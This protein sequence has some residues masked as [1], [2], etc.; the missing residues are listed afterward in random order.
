M[1]AQLA[2]LIH[3]EHD[4]VQAWRLSGGLASELERQGKRTLTFPSAAIVDH[5][6]ASSVANRSEACLRGITSRLCT[7]EYLFSGVRW[8]E[9]PRA[10]SSHGAPRRIGILTLS[11]RVVHAALKQVLEPMVDHRFV[12]D[13]FGFRAARSVTGALDRALHLLNAR[14]RTTA[15]FRYLARLDVADCFETLQHQ[16]LLQEV[17]GATADAA[18]LQILGNAL[19]ATGMV[20]GRWWWRR[21]AGVVQGS[22]LSPLLCNLYLHGVD[23]ELARASHDGARWRLLRYADDMLLLADS[24]RSC[25][26]GV[27]RIA[28]ALRA[29]GQSLR[30]SKTQVTT[31]R[32]GASWLGVDIRLGAADQRYH[33]LI[34]TSR[35][36]AMRERI[37]EMTV[38]PSERIDPAAFDMGRWLGS[39]NE[40]MMDWWHAYRYA[41]NG[42]FVFKQIDEF[43][44]ERVGELLPS[45]M[46]RTWRQVKDEHQVRLPRGF[47]SW[48]IQ[49]VTLTLLSSLPPHS[50][51]FLSR[52]PLWQMRPKA[53]APSA[54][55]SAR[56]SGNG[57]AW[58]E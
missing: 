54:P 51:H 12:D 21:P 14:H 35:L 29:R 52:P 11:D 37:A 24:R 57:R 31:A 43:A 20:R 53:A 10:G 27:A 44:V 36:E 9:I 28:A 8:L 41:E 5:L 30:R 2:E 58:V 34:P 26:Q 55:P 33:Y 48:K 7:G 39:I 18:V 16:R 6:S 45:V 13:S 15:P 46:G 4:V 17:S 47:L 19:R 32:D 49:G 23:L 38:P 50:P 25:R 42:L 56:P 40:Q 3:P 1:L 22:S